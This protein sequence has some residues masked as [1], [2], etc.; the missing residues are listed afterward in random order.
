MIDLRFRPKADFMLTA[1]WQQLYIL[2]EHWQND[3]EFFKDEIKFMLKL[4]DKYFVWLL[5]D[6]DL[7]EVQA[8]MKQIRKLEVG[9]DKIEN[10]IVL[11]LSH[12]SSVI[13]N[14]N[15]KGEI[16]EE[17]QFREEHEDLEEELTLYTKDLRVVK[18]ELF[19]LTEGV[20]ETEK[21][22]HLLHA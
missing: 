20:M 13:E 1:D 3:V 12:I 9:C 21:W 8:I 2:T 11:H 22:K 7:T 10:K 18:K 16:K 17:Q 19:K 4:V 6:E 15:N 5:A 14:S